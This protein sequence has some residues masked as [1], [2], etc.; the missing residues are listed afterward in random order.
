MVYTPQPQSGINYCH[1]AEGNV[2]S[3]WSVAS[4][5]PVGA[6]MEFFTKQSLQDSTDYTAPCKIVLIILLKLLSAL[7]RGYSQYR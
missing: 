4:R 6:S 5:R 7:G 1:Y 2:A 3:E